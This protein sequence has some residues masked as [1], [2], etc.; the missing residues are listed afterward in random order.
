MS[1]LAASLP[2]ITFSGTTAAHMLKQAR[3]VPV[4]ILQM[5]IKHGTKV[6]DPQGVANAYKYTIEIFKNGNYYELEIVAIET[7]KG[8]FHVLHFLYK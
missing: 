8:V 5:A 4:Q 1:D 2:T 7:G 6:I 3:H